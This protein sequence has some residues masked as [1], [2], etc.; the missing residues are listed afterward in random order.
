MEYNQRF[1]LLG[2]DSPTDKIK[3]MIKNTGR[4]MLVDFDDIR[5]TDLM[6]DLTRDEIEA[7]YRKAYGSGRKIDT[8]YDFSTRPERQWVVYSAFCLIIAVCYMF[9][10]IAAVKPVFIKDLDIIVTP[11]TFIYPFT[12]LIIDLI[13]EFY[14]IK[15]AK[16]AIYICV[17][18]NALLLL[19]LHISLSLPVLP[20][21]IFNGSY[22]SLITQIESTFIASSIA[23]VLS[24][25]ANS[26]T[27]I[28]IK[29]LTNSRH[30]YIRVL[31]S[32]LVASVVD[33]FVFSFIAFSGIMSNEQV[34]S[35][36]YVQIT[37]KIGYALINVFPAYGARYL[38][39]KY[40]A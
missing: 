21:W 9:S 19:L 17:L 37:V 24:E 35:M 4:V 40:L 26:H 6:D 18:S 28:K 11:G 10:N 2:F 12:F 31:A 15:L 14:G 3:L 36:I 13:N 34:M 5:N 33:S 39:K 30:L 23:F 25:L 38:F 22:S 29:A 27:L 16:K 32:T 8:Q 20:E 7:I 1:K